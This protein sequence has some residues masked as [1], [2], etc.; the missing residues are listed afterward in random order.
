MLIVVEA[1]ILDRKETPIAANTEAS[2][3]EGPLPAAGAAQ[4]GAALADLS[5]AVERLQALYASLPDASLA[6]RDG[7]EW[8]PREALIHLVFWHEQY[9]AAPAARAAGGGAAP[10]APAL[11][12]WDAPGAG[13]EPALVRGTFKEW[14]A[15]AVERERDVPVPALLARLAGAHARF[16]DAARGADALSWR[17]SFREGSKPWPFAEALRL[18]ASHI[19]LHDGRVRKL[20][21]PVVPARTRARKPMTPHGPVTAGC[22]AHRYLPRGPRDEVEVLSV[23]GISCR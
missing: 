3:R 18:I 16:G 5:T 17:M 12:E 20:A 19:R 9:A 7:P 22:A 11:K 1:A 14:N 6:H 13:R 15:R 10:V 8:G 2:H 4:V 23:A 21:R